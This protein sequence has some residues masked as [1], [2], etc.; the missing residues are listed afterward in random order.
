MRN[1]IKAL[2]RNKMPVSGFAGLA[3][4]MTA[5]VVSMT[6]C[7]DAAVKEKD[8]RI[9]VTEQPQD[10]MVPEGASASF[11]VGTRAEKIAKF[12][13]QFNGTNISGATNAV[14]V[15]ETE[16]GLYTCLIT[17]GDRSILSDSAGLF[18][19]T[20]NALGL[21]TSVQGPFQPYPQPVGIHCGSQP[22][23]VNGY[24]GI[25][26]LDGTHF[27]DVGSKTQ[28]AADTFDVADCPFDTVITAVERH[29]FSKPVPSCNDNASGST[30]PCTQPG[31]SKL[32]F[33]VTPNVGQSYSFTIYTKPPTCPTK[34]YK[35]K[36]NV[37]WTPP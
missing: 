2:I 24:C 26:N 22:I 33:A 17:V 8:H 21:L 10:Q 32:T 6:G 28:C 27:F 15:G 14:L 35:L 23:T 34:G 11:A 5:L 13:W 25:T 3:L 7:K 29:D 12:Q 4:V 16:V 18:V 9:L 30:A 37:N 31:P 20:T 19:F 36:L 1:G